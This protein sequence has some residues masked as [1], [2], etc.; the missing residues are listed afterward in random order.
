MRGMIGDL[1]TVSL[2]PEG[3]C[4]AL[5]QTVSHFEAQSGL[6]A[7]LDVD[8]AVAALCEPGRLSPFIGLQI[9]RIVQEALANVRRH[10]GAP[11]RIALSLRVDAG[12][13]RLA[14]TDDGAGFSPAQSGSSDG[15][16]GLQVMRQRAERIGGRLAVYSAP[17]EGTRVEMCVPVGAIGEV[18]HAPAVG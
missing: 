18:P 6:A 4:A 17:G 15:H 12:Q 9:I 14:I 11:D 5:R 8:G 10:A 3:L 1:L 7:R 16:F 2:S 13:L